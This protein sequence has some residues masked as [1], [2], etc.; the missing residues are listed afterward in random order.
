MITL[1]L[2][3]PGVPQRFSAQTGSASLPLRGV[4]QV[5]EDAMIVVKS[6]GKR[7]LWADQ[8]CVEQEDAEIKFLQIREID[9]VY[10]RAYATDADDF[11]DVDIHSGFLDGEGHTYSFTTLSADKEALFSMHQTPE[12]IL[13]AIGNLAPA[14]SPTSDD[15]AQL[16]EA[17]KQHVERAPPLYLP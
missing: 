3:M 14:L 10:A 8:W 13:R 16:R 6:L 4:S 9:L 2:V 17:T 7:Y 1:L 11:N 5:I 15:I 12:Q